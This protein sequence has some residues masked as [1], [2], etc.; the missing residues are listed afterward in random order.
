[1]SVQPAPGTARSAAQGCSRL[2]CSWRHRGSAAGL[3]RQS[4]ASQL[5]TA[6]LNSATPPSLSPRD[7]CGP[8]FATGVLAISSGSPSAVRP[9]LSQGGVWGGD[10]CSPPRDDAR[11]GKHHTHGALS[12]RWSCLGHASGHCAPAPEVS[13]TPTPRTSRR[14]ATQGTPR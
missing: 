10:G 8:S 9:W 7:S 6:P 14:L 2:R 13:R 1:M 5:P 3:I 11:S 12:S 4:L